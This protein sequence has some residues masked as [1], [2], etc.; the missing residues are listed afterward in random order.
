MAEQVWLVPVTPLQRLRLWELSM[1]DGQ[2]VKGQQGRVYRRFK[3]AFAL[4]SVEDAVKKA[5]QKALGMPHDNEPRLFEITAENAGYVRKIDDEVDR[6]PNAED[7]LGDLFD[8][9]EG[10]KPGKNYIPPDDVPEF[11]PAA[12]E[13]W[14]LKDAKDPV[15]EAVEHIA[16]F[17]RAQGADS[18]ADSIEHGDWEPK[19]GLKSDE[20]NTPE[21]AAQAA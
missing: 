17:C 8:I 4:Q 2:K 5:A 14:S 20:K 15:D 9:C 13:D 1:A 6:P 10:L 11:D 19:N 18:L 7:A 16:A 21:E 12:T 3:R